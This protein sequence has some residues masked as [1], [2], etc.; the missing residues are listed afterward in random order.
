M[1]DAKVAHGC[2]RLLSPSHAHGQ[3]QDPGF[4]TKVKS[5]LQ[6]SSPRISRTKPFASNPCYAY[7]QLGVNVAADPHG[8][9][10]A[11][12][13]T[14]TTTTGTGIPTLILNELI[15][16]FSPFRVSP[17]AVASSSLFAAQRQ[18]NATLG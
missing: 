8:A 3:T 13:G 1:V 15:P 4:P 10:Y 9:Y 12:H 7:K 18:P 11:Y 14:M 2:V 6:P 5:W 16:E 17:A